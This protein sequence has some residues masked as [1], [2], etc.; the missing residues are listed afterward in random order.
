MSREHLF[1]AA[2]FTSVVSGLWTGELSAQ[3]DLSGQWA[4]R[5]HEDQPS[6]GPGLEIGEWE[7]LP[8]N[9]AARL[10]AESWTASVY[11]VPERQCI[12]FAADMGLT[13][14][15]VRI[16]SDVDRSSQQVIAW[17]IH[18]EWQAQDQVIWMDGRPRP[19][20]YAA[21]SWQGFST[22]KWEGNTLTV[23][24]T[25]LKW[26]YL[27]RNGVPRSDQATLTEHYIRHGDTLTVVQIITDPVYTTE[28]MIR[29][30]NLVLN[31]EQQFGGYTCRPAAEILNRRIMESMGLKRS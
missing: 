20:A 3:K 29:T 8:I 19:P 2:L 31:P 21:H 22:G 28:P 4:N 5:I 12:P 6:R 18:H 15:N 11:T 1:R 25:H 14:G 7:G 16:W 30:R 23:S 17:H 27:E 9:R 10:K 24:T 13:I 26:A